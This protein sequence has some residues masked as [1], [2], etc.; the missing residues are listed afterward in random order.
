MGAQMFNAVVSFAGTT[1][2]PEQRSPA[3]WSP[4]LAFAPGSTKV[5]SS[6]LATSWQGILLERHLSSPG[7]RWGSS[8]DRHV[9]ST[10]VGASARF[11]YRAR[12]GEC[13]VCVNRPGTIMITPSSSATE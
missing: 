7:A 2:G 11:E 3:L 9:V 8:I 1:E 13:V 12:S 5:L 4:L 10:C 6:S